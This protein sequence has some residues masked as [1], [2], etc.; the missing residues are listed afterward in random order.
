M[1]FWASPNATTNTCPITP[2]CRLAGN[3][4]MYCQLPPNLIQVCNSFGV[5]PEGAANLV[6]TSGGVLGGTMGFAFH[7][8]AG[9]DVG[10]R[11]KIRTR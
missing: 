1:L 11:F 7:A 4:V 2:P 5:G 8:F 6:S 10:M 9:G 3:A